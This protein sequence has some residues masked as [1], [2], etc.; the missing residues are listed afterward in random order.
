MK[1]FSKVLFALLILCG[2]CFFVS[3][4]TNT[5]ERNED[6]ETEEVKKALEEIQV[7]TSSVKMEYFLGQAFESAGLKVVAKYND[8]TSEDV[9]SQAVVDSASFDANALGEY[10]I[11]VSYTYEGRVRTGNYTVQVKTILENITTYIVGLEV[12]LGKTTY[13]VNDELDLTDLSVSAIYSDE[14]K[15]VLEASAYTVDSSYIDKT[16]G[17]ISPLIVSTKKT[18]ES[19]QNSQEVEVKSFVMITYLNPLVSIEFKSGTIEFEYGSK[20]SIDDWKVEATYT[21]GEVGEVTGFTVNKR[22]NTHLSGPVSLTISYSEMNIVKNCVVEIVVAENP[23]PDAPVKFE[24]N[25][26][27]LELKATITEPLVIDDFVTI[28]AASGKANKIDAN[29]KSYGDEFTFNRRINL[30]GKVEIGGRNIQILMPKAGKIRVIF[31]QGNSG[32]KMTLLDSSGSTVGTSETQ[33]AGNDVLVEWTFTVEEAGYYYLGGT[34]GI[35]VWYIGV[36]A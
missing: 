5:P 22:V 18:Y 36:D 30:Q 9:S 6:L 27:D 24:I 10:L 12:S 28:N 20:F 1:K 17:N 7:D 26:N 13:D 2:V 19:G 31:S 16:K 15:E 14:T 11:T 29:S 34:S 23:N 32:R 33:T 4:K 35:Y 21:N 25:A 8:E 3:C